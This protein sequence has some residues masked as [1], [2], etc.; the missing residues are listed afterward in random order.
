M[1]SPCNPAQPHGGAA[2]TAAFRLGTLKR[3]DCELGNLLEHSLNE[4][5]ADDRAALED[6]HAQVRQ[7]LGAA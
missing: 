1:S 3:V 7:A 2:E 4:L 5:H 6:L